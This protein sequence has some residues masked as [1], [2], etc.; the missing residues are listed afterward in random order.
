VVAEKERL[1][2][3][4]VL[5]GLYNYHYLRQFLASELRRCA[6]YHKGTFIL[7]IDVDWFKEVNDNH[8]HVTGSDILVELGRH[9][10]SMVRESDVVVRYGGDEFVIILTETNA[11][12]AQAIAER[13]RK[14]VESHIFGAGQ[15]LEVR[16][17]VSIGVAGYPE[18][19]SS[20]EE[21][22]RRADGA[23]YEAK[24]LR[25]NTVR[26]AG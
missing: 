18:H 6:R 25:K 5:T 1:T 10:S 17:T 13:V 24:N 3:T 26:I 8:G 9:F 21:L 16:I 22:I 20:V 23:M 12:A 15:H 4:D 7:F 2:F 19:G 11:V 14:S